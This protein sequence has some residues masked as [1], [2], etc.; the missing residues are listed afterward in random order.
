M[1]LVCEHNVNFHYTM[2]IKFSCFILVDITLY[3][4]SPHSPPH[5]TLLQC[6]IKGLNG[7]PMSI[8]EQSLQK[9]KG[10]LLQ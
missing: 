3:P 4:V 2:S 7:L 10:E 1:K 9:A 8:F 6:D 5:L